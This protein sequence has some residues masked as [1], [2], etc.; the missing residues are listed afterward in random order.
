MKEIRPP[1]ERVIFV[2]CNERPEGEDAC[3]NRGSVAIRDALKEEVKRRGA[4][5]RIRVSRAMCFG[6]CAI[7]PNVSI[8]PDNVWLHAVRAEDVPEIVRRFVSG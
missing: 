2:C 1:Y 4:A 8:Q 5:A 7:G 6:L 3:A